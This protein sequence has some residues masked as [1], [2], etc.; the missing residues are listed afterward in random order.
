MQ[1]L[2]A[3]SG[4]VAENE[5]VEVRIVAKW[6]Q[7]MIMLRSNTQIRLEIEGALERLEREIN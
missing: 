5:P 7:I 1:N 4:R 2:V 6:I 3:R